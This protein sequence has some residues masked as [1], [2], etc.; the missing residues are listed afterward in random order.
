[1][2]SKVAQ[3]AI[4]YHL[5]PIQNGGAVRL[6]KGAFAEGK[7]IAFT[8]R[9]DID[10]NY[11]RLAD[12]MLSGEARETGFYPI[13]GTHD[14]RLIDRIIEIAHSRKW[15]KEEY[16]FEMLYGV[17]NEYEEELVRAGEQLRLYLPFGTDWWP[18]S[19][20]RVGESPKNARFL[21]KQPTPE[22]PALV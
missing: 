1:M 18:Y 12:M 3:K 4:S 10:H 9:D 20:R 8:N 7:K 19:V 14:D 5:S 6:V 2:V 16:E 13:F 21:S 15:K 22:G 11:I 17:R